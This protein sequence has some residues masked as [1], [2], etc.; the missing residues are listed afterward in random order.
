MTQRQQYKSFYG[1]I[2]IILVIQSVLFLCLIL[3][4]WYL[5]VIQSEKYR[6]LSED[7]AIN[8][9]FIF[10]ERGQILDRK[11]KVLV[12]NTKYYTASF[13][14]ERSKNTNETLDYVASLLHLNSDVL[15]PIKKEASRIPSY[16]PL[17]IKDHLSCDEITALELATLH[18][19]SLSIST[20]T[21]RL[22]QS[23]YEVGNLLGYVAKPTTKDVE[24]DRSL[25]MPGAMIGKGGLEKN[26]NTILRGTPG[27]NEIEVNARGRSVR[28][29]KS[30]P[31]ISGDNLHLTIDLDLQKYTYQKLAPY[32]SGVA[33]IMDIHTGD[34]LTF[35]STPSYDPQNFVG[36]INPMI[37]KSLVENPLSPLVN[38]GIQG[39]Y[40]P[41]SIFKLVVA[42]AALETGI[43]PNDTCTCHGKVVIGGHAF[44]CYKK[45]GHGALNMVEA[46][47][48]SCDVYFY[49]LA[50]RL[51][52]EA[53]A[54]MAK[55]LGFGAITGVDL[56]SEKMGN[57]P[58][59]TWKKRILKEPW[60]VGDTVLM[61][62]GQGGILVTPL[63][64]ITMMA[65]IANGGYKVTPH[66]LAN[67]QDFHKS[68]MEISKKSR[69]IILEGLARA[70]N[71][72]GGTSYASRIFHKGME[73]GGKTAT[74]QVRRISKEERL[75]GV[76][77]HAQMPWH[78]R[79]HAMFVGFAPVNNPKYAVFVLVEHGGWGA[80]VA[81]PI[82]RDLIL[83]AQQLTEEG[84]GVPHEI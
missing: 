70:T 39:L 3:R 14:R 6:I 40:S 84:R 7:N 11:G 63:Q 76:R 79:D 62:I 50:R 72:E 43:N 20:R 57:I 22:Y 37:W 61:S 64:I 24:K 66:L 54:R 29:I 74:A 42:L 81:A 82:A 23:H 2:Q 5:Q 1:R 65:G 8:I 71:Q 17:E 41:A 26:Y 73:M 10:P 56:P 59:P 35:V 36:G 48:K 30:L 25:M 33:I 55:K 60:Y 77:T 68:P 28:C 52:H 12:Q 58:S 32:K 53:I 46:I 27:K 31:P 4:L 83:K 44:H 51:G 13:L 15:D 21:N 49:E 16:I 38:K 34:L 69:D 80:Q 75:R 18:Y 78:L 47:K 9:E 67:K 19:P 45:S